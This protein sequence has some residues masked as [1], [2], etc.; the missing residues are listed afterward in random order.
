MANHWEGKVPCQGTN[1]NRSL[2]SERTNHE[3]TAPVT[4]LWETDSLKNV[5]CLPLFWFQG[6]C[7]QGSLVKE[8][9]SMAKSCPPDNSLRPTK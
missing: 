7:L 6:I 4:N 2:R 9:S 3:A 1:P 5:P 8:T